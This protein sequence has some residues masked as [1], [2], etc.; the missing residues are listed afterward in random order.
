STRPFG[1]AV[2]DGIDLDIE[3]GNSKYY[4]SFINQLRSHTD[5]ASK[6]YYLTAAPQCPYPDE[7]VGEAL[8]AVA[9]DAVYVQ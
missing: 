1:T 4:D 7:F 5:A 6:T 8:N 9:F 2:L 3:S